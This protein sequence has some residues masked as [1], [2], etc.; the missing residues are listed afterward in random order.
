MTKITL[1]DEIYVKIGRNKNT[2]LTKKF[3]WRL[4]NKCSR[5]KPDEENISPK[6]F[7]NLI[8]SLREYPLRGEDLIPSRLDHKNVHDIRV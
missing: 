1:C 4:I 2:K 3:C 6:N 8:E 7:K 5:K